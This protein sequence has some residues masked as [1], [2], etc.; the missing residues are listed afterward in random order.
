MNDIEKSFEAARMAPVLCE[1]VD[2]YG[3]TVMDKFR[4]G[5]RFPYFQKFRKEDDRGNVWTLLFYVLSKEMKK[6][7]LYY[8]M[9]YITYDIPRKRKEDDV[10]AGRG[11]LL[12]DPLA[13]NRV[14]NKVPG[15]RQAIVMDIVPH[16]FNRY[17]SRYLKPLGKDGMDF[18]H[19]LENM[20]TRWQWFDICADLFGDENAKKHMN[21][22]GFQYDVFMRGGG[23]LRGQM[24]H[25]L[26]IRFTTYISEDMMYEDQ[27]KRQSEMQSEY[28]KLKK[29]GL[30]EEMAKQGK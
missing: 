10:N 16:A 1:M 2:R 11:C 29:D 15:C 5:A 27:Q 21:D 13:M 23:M 4:R 3:Y 19:K 18:D 17:T 6:K 26:L 8:T 9:A 12:L 20:L 25:N 22:D 28:F 30:F 14:L 7:G 24:V